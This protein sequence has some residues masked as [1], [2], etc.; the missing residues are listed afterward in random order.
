M[1]ATISFNCLGC[2]EEL[3]ADASMAGQD[4]PCPACGKVMTVPRQ[5]GRLAIKGAAKKQPKVP[6][7]AGPTTT[8]SDNLSELAD[9]HAFG[10]EREDIIRRRRM[11]AIAKQVLVL[12]SLLASLVAVGYGVWRFYDARETIK[13]QNQE[14]LMRRQDASNR[15]SEL[16]REARQL[17]YEA[18][19]M[20]SRWKLTGGLGYL[21]LRELTSYH[22]AG[23][24]AK[25]HKRWVEWDS[26][27]HGAI[28]EALRSV[29]KPE[30]IEPALQTVIGVAMGMGDE[31]A[32]LPP[33]DELRYILKGILKED[34]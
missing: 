5:R 11:I 28:M 8:Q 18:S 16:Q 32:Q 12:I 1:D 21:F 25:A 3:E 27:L 30:D 24:A 17:D 29:S 31:P 19:R 26:T 34:R 15:R 10:E 2:Q 14:E 6:A 23:G 33:L 9:V 22:G 20:N 7:G 13:R 4:L